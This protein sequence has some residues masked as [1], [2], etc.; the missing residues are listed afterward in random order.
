MFRIYLNKGRKREG[1]R[2]GQ[3]H[4]STLTSF[5]CIFFELIHEA[6]H[7][8]GTENNWHIISAPTHSKHFTAYLL[9]KS[10]VSPPTLSPP[11]HLSALEL[12]ELLCLSSQPT[13]SD[14]SYH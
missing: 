1:A 4:R 9:P 10:G 13:R 5:A 2:L 11:W 7:I 6:S 8:W 12:F 14:V 3:K